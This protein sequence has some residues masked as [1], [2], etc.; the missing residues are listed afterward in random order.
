MDL[1]SPDLCKIQAQAKENCT[2]VLHLQE[3]MCQEE[4][5]Q[6]NVPPCYQIRMNDFCYGRHHDVH[7]DH[8]REIEV[9][10]VISER[11]Q[12]QSQTSLSIL[13]IDIVKR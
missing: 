12:L 4:P 9:N 1:G 5:G 2:L 8:L 10:L 11:K 7:V 13:L 3:E 6:R